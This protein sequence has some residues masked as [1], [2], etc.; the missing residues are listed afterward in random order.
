MV[1]FF[2]TTLRDGEQSPGVS[3]TSEDKL[4]I[5]RE[6][7]SIRVDVIESGSPATSEGEREGIKLIAN[8]GLDAEI[9]VY[10]R[11][12]KKDI[13]LAL[14]CDVDSV[15]LVVPSSDLH[16]KKKLKKD[17]NSVKKGAIETVEYAK[18]HGLVVELSGEDASRADID[19]LKE[20]YS[21]GIEAGADRIC[22]CDTVGLLVP[23]R[24]TEIFSSLSDLGV[25]VSV[26]CH[27]DFGLATA[28]SLAAIKSGASQI[29]VTVNGIGERAGNASLEEVVM[30]LEALY[31]I[32]TRIVKEDLYHVSKL[33]SRLTKMDVAPNKPIVGDNAFTHESGIHVHG[34]NSD[35]STYEP[36]PPETVGRSRRFIFGKHT[37]GASVRMAL[38]ELGLQANDEQLNDILIRVKEMGDKGKR[39]TD[40]DLMAIA[41]TVLE[42][43]KEPRI[44]LSDLTIVSG[45]M[46]MPTASIKLNID[47]EDVIEAG[48]G[49]GP[50]D[51]AINALR[52]ATRNSADVQLDEYHVDAIKGGADALV[53]V[54]VR[55]SK[56]DKVISAR[57]ANVDIIMASIEALIQGIN[58]LY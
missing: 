9:C 26:H 58:R 35:T 51:A 25:G 49:V 34:L 4:L 31:N 41:E 7:D 23:E 42:I 24:T 29:H 28:N 40:T 46:I 32:D 16:I 37:G 18:D 55:L 22:F 45:K 3:L 8:E 2:D 48:T 54:S 6:L 1:N 47:G 53:E 50:V 36:I 33:V 20:L 27:D 44:K 43:I 19:F 56:G 57:S 30:I 21:Q 13:D 10:T 39:V 11:S 38:K 12:L 17:R 15:H 52:K 5:A 14:N